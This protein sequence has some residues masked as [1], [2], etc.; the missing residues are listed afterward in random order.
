[1]SESSKPEIRF[2]DLVSKKHFIRTDYDIVTKITDSKNGPRKITFYVTDNPTPRRDGAKF[3][4][5][6]IMKNEKV[7]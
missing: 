4:S 1:M 5:W 2:F 7:I 6:K 3:Q